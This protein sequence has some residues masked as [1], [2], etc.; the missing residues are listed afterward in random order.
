MVQVSVNVNLIHFTLL[1]QILNH[2]I[3]ICGYMWLICDICL[4][5]EYII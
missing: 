1:H 5:G 3:S 2:V 4:T